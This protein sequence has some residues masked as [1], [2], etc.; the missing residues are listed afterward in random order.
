MNGM[1]RLAPDL[2]LHHG[3]IYTLAG[4][5][6]VVEA[7]AVKEGRIL[8]VGGNAPLLAL[9]DAQTRLIDLQGRSVIPG[10]FDS[11]NHLLQVGVKLTRIRLD[12]CRSAAEMMELVRAR[13]QVTPPGHWIIGEGWSEHNFADNRLPTRF[14]LDPA[15]DQH[16]VIL[17]RFFNMDVV[18]T[19]ALRLAGLHKQSPDPE[20]GRIERDASGE[21]T[22]I[23]RASAKL[24]VRS[25]LPRPMLAELKTALQLGC[26]EMN[27]FGITSVI[28]PGLYPYEMHAYQSFYADGK[29]TVRMN[30]MPSWHGFREDEQEAEL[31]QRATALGIYSGLGDEWLRIGGLKMAID[32]GTSSHTAYMYEP[33]EGE[34]VVGNFNRL[35]PEQLRR[36]F[37]TAQ[38]HGWDVGIHTCG[39]RAMD[40]VVDAFADVLRELKP[41]DARHNVIHAYFPSDRALRQMGE[42]QIGAVIQPTF[43]YWEGDM[44][45]RDVGRARAANYKP[46]R[47]FLDHNI[48]LAANSDIPSTV[49]P[50]PFVALYALVTRL[51]N[52]GN[53]VAP[54]QALTREEALHAYTQ[55]GTWLTREEALKGTLAVG[56]VADLVVL[57]RDYFQVSNAEIKEIQALMTIAGGKVVWP[58]AEV[59]A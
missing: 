1:S 45:F 46:A 34:T 41:R 25:L 15:T 9:A 48:P 10:I 12:E 16:P 5:P 47:K 38:E 42:Q 37:R 6:S 55:G 29:L 52:L 50:N 51:N 36:Y 39:D 3:R 26:Q 30:L 44:I 28:D 35:N 4:E 13:A 27:R 43:L 22:G 17:M 24:L 53:P 11:H 21:L 7:V 23:L 40:M 57:D 59:A 56:K 18:N 31:D 33:F 14:D 8:T 19:V 54:D 20:G 49:S 2:I 32:G 58:A